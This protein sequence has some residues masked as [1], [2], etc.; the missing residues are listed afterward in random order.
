MS[1]TVV[2]FPQFTR[3]GPQQHEYRQR[4]AKL[5]AGKSIKDMRR[6]WDNVSDHD[7]FYHAPNGELYDCAD[8][9]S[10]MNMLGDG[11]YCAV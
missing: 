9:H 2:Q 3:F 7:S 8:I 6:M 4:L 11:R 1:A 10:Y 5:F